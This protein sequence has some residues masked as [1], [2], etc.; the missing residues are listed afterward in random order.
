MTESS[1]GA[2]Q[3]AACWERLRPQAPLVQCLTNIVAA[4]LSANVLLAAGASPAMVD[5]PHEAGGF[6]RIADAVL[7][8]L[9]TPDDDTAEGMRV[10]VVGARDAA[11][12]WVLDP[13]AVGGLAWRTGL[14][15]E[16]LDSAA[17]AI[18]R[19]NA[20][21]ILALAGGAGSRGVDAT[22]TTQACSTVAAEL[23]TQHR[24]T[25][26]VS[27][28]VDLLTDG[29]RVVRV[30][31]GHPVMTQITGVGCSLG[32]LMAATCAVEADRL[33]A[34]TTATAALTLAA[35]QAAADSP[36]P[37]SVA[38]ALLDRLAALNPAQLADGTRLR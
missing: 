31:N 34:A 29:Q 17:P 27:G 21:E 23:A 30:D 5:N 35:E 16:L 12:P 38:V 14:A 15:H 36:G 26:A 32:A 19:G 6:A 13:V 7:V 22:D 4:P 20:S 24:C 18:I 25:V 37:G 33:L 2:D 10:A 9:G 8:N 1:L 3:V 28:P 11:T